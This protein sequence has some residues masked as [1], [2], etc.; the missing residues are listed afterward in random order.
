MLINTRLQV[1]IGGPGLETTTMKNASSI[2]AIVTLAVSAS[3]AFADTGFYGEAGVGKTVITGPYNGVEVEG[4]TFALRVGH[5]WQFAGTYNLTFTAG[6]FGQASFYN[7]D[8]MQ[9]VYDCL[10]ACKPPYEHYQGLEADY[11]GD[12][13]LKIGLC[14]KSFCGFASRALTGVNLG[15][16]FADRY[17][18]DPSSNYSYGET[19]FAKGDTT[20]FAADAKF[21]K[22]RIGGFYATTDLTI[23]EFQYTGGANKEQA[24]MERYGFFVR[25]VG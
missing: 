25:F 23:K 16:R 9:K 12:A 18:T 17:P 5:D 3:S 1:L 11:G 6:I 7:V 21:G 13:G 20:E 15:Q 2:F 10:T 22:V 4:E 14:Y 24:E 19:V 8:G